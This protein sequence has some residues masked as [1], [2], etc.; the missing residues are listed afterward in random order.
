[1]D[2]GIAVRVESSASTLWI[3]DSR[4]SCHPCAAVLCSLHICQGCGYEHSGSS[5]CLPC[6]RRG[7]GVECCVGMQSS[8]ACPSPWTG[9]NPETTNTRGL[10]WKVM[11]DTSGLIT[12]RN[13]MSKGLFGTPRVDTG[14]ITPSTSRY[15]QS[16]TSIPAPKAMIYNWVAVRIYL[17]RAIFRP[18]PVDSR[19]W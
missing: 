1:M 8:T 15:E 11:Y 13:M 2:P 7:P 6:V 12:R 19:A 9:S 4:S 16:S 3:V 17:R 10:R 5:M 14:S 18:A